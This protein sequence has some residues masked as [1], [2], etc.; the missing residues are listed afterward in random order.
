MLCM[1]CSHCFPQ[2]HDVIPLGNGIHL[3]RS[4]S[5]WSTLLSTSAGSPSGP[6]HYFIHSYN[7]FFLN[8][9]LLVKYLS[10]QF[11]LKG[12][13]PPTSI[14]FS[15]RDYACQIN[16]PM[17]ASDRLKAWRRTPAQLACKMRPAFSD[18]PHHR[19]TVQQHCGQHEE[20]QVLAS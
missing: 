14:A 10:N 3:N 1:L 15:L 2:H 4:R 11:P 12:K 6:I 5:T 20:V 7:H 16:Y 17:L 18:G 9:L 8:Y 19:L 13:L